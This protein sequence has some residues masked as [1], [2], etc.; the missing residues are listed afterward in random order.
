[1]SPW[2]LSQQCWLGGTAVLDVYMM[3]KYFHPAIVPL[4]VLMTY[5][6]WY[7]MRRSKEKHER[8]LG[9]K[10]NLPDCNSKF[11]RLWWLI[12]GLLSLVT[13]SIS[14]YDLGG[15]LIVSAYYFDSCRA[16]SNIEFR[17]L[18]HAGI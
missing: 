1:M 15:F 14:L 2:L 11:F 16:P 17:R 4:V 7:M 9:G 13:L 3:T 6:G 5:G 12:L 8:W 10:E 18:V